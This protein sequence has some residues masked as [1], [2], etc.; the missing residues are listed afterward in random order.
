MSYRF[1]AS[2]PPGEWINDPNALFFAEGRYHL[3]VQHAADFADVRRIGWGT[4]PV[5]T[6]RGGAGKAW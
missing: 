3:F 6:S 1:H 5:E 2:A 4:S